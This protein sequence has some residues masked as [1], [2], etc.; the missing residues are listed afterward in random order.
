MKAQYFLGRS[1]SGKTHHC[2][3]QI[4]DELRRRS[5]G[6][7]LLFLVPEQATFQMEQA[8]LSDPSLRGFHRVSVLSFDRLARQVLLE[9]WQPANKSASLLKPLRESGRQM[10]LKRLLQEQ[11][12]KLVA[13]SRSSGSKGFIA[14]LSNMVCE[15][16][17]YQKTA[18]QLRD[19]AEALREGGQP[20]DEPLAEKLE[21]LSFLLRAYEQAI[22]QRFM[23]PNDFR[24]KM[25]EYVG[26]AEF[27]GNAR[28]WIAGT[29]AAF[30][31]H[32]QYC[33]VAP[34]D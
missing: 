26:Q 29:T 13:F 27:L 15:C 24:D 33:P 30:P 23:D 19:Q 5:E 28:L 11:G 12:E 20:Q 4:Q 25:C 9:A 7:P 2:I 32:P 1:G 34:S 10:L 21:D 17:Q 14:K 18:N 31:A 8:I 3:G 6:E 22:D 16:H